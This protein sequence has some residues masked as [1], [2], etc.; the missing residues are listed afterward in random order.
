MVANVKNIAQKREERRAKQTE[1]KQELDRRGKNTGASEFS[2]MVDQ[3]REQAFQ[4]P[5]LMPSG[6][7][8]VQ[9]ITVCVRKRPLNSRER[10]ASDVDVVSMPNPETTMVHECKTKVDLTKYL[11]H[12]NF[13]FDYAFNENVGNRMVYD[14]TA[15]PL[16]ATIF[17]KGMATCFAYGQTGSGKTHTMGGDFQSGKSQDTSAGIYALAAADVFRLNAS[18]ANAS[19]NLSI[20]VSFFEIYGGRVYDLLNKQKRLRVL[21]DGKNVVQIVGLSE[22][23]VTCMDDVLAALQHGSNVSMGKVRKTGGMKTK[24]IGEERQERERKAN[25]PCE[26]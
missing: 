1:Q 18:P 15:A 19:K 22:K 13:R 10:G 14:Y 17:D 9:K 21:E 5:P 4:E 11:E 2:L 23:V 24:E 12:H 7:A 6:A 8:A 20:S 26:Y 25:E 3:Y 16:V